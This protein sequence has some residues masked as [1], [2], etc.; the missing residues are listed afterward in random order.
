MGLRGRGGQPLKPITPR[1]PSPTRDTQGHLCLVGGD[2]PESGN[3]KEDEQ[4]LQ[5]LVEEAQRYKQ[6]AVEDPPPLEGKAG[7]EEGADVNKDAKETDQSRT[8]KQTHLKPQHD[9]RTNLDLDHQRTAK[10]VHATQQKD[11]DHRGYENQSVA[12]PVEADWQKSMAVCRPKEGLPQSATQARP[13]HQECVAEGT[14]ESGNPIP[15]NPRRE[16]PSNGGLAKSADA[17]VPAIPEHLTRTSSA[18]SKHMS[19]D[20]QG[21]S[22]QTQPAREGAG[23]EAG[24]SGRKKA[25]E[26]T[27]LR[28]AAP[29]AQPACA[30]LSS[31]VQAPPAEA[32]ELHH[33]GESTARK[34]EEEKSVAQEVIYPSYNPQ[35]ARTLTR[36]AVGCRCTPCPSSSSGACE[37]RQLSTRGTSSC[38]SEPDSNQKCDP[39]TRTSCRTHHQN[40]PA[41]PSPTSPGPLAQPADTKPGDA[42]PLHSR[43]TSPCL[44]KRTQDYQASAPRELQGQCGDGIWRTG[45]TGDDTPH[46]QQAGHTTPQT[47]HPQQSKTKEEQHQ[48]S[49]D[50]RGDSQNRACARPAESETEAHHQDALWRAPQSEG[51]GRSLTTLTKW[52]GPG[53]AAVL[54]P[55][56][57][58]RWQQELVKVEDPPALR[59]TTLKR[60]SATSLQNL[61]TLELVQDYVQ[62]AKASTN[63]QLNCYQTTQPRRTAAVDPEKTK[64]QDQRSGKRQNDLEEAESALAVELSGLTNQQALCASSSLQQ[65]SSAFGLATN[66]TQEEPPAMTQGSEDYH[67]LAF[68]QLSVKGK[69]V[70]ALLDTG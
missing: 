44:T 64:A 34:E 18:K 11:V 60:P 43:Y 39:Q 49:Q 12:E 26:G 23:H 4:A 54:G 14:A 41:F 51:T 29:K 53:D 52:L 16:A 25:T 57:R 61:R 7:E 69:P 35:L 40:L 48:S 9:G 37:R 17:Q 30:P 19:A 42:I 31:H 28:P 1:T 38:P 63:P 50:E 59:W 22:R 55:S 13:P 70:I 8:H 36:A 20:E 46:P 32:L 5:Q 15:G 21:P 2:Q 68:L 10:T 58:G 65:P 66:G 3:T 24:G 33:S 47:Q 67:P 62:M 27:H 45:E 6:T 56:R